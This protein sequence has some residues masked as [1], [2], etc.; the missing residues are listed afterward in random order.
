[1]I[2]PGLISLA[3]SLDSLR[4]RFNADRAAPRLMALVSPT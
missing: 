1:V 3:G 4:A 2:A